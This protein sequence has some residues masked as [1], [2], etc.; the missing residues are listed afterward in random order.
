MKAVEL[1]KYATFS[2]TIG[3][4]CGGPVI[5]KLPKNLLTIIK[6]VENTASS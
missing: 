5:Y 1:V 2:A 3:P 6:L 4:N